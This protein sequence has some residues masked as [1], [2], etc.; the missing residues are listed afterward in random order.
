MMMIMSSRMESAGLLSASQWHLDSCFAR[1]C[2]P[3][4][5]KKREGF[6][7]LVQ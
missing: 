6:E 2:P 5:P 1:R 7:P 4:A 3:H